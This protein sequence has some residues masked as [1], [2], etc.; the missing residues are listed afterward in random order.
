[1]TCVELGRSQE[2]ISLWEWKL[3][4]SSSTK[5]RTPYYDLHRIKV[6]TGGLFSMK[7]ET[8]EFISQYIYRIDLIIDRINS[9]W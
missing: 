8:E 1:M 3:V 9:P 2:G 4:N 7:M 5:W 6:I